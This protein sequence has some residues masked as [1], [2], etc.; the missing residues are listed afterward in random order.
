MELISMKRYLPGM[1]DKLCLVYFENIEEPKIYRSQNVS[2]GKYVVGKSETYITH[3]CYVPE[4][5][6]V[7]E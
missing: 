1:N 2:K 5:S 6:E 4:L 7:K 3:W